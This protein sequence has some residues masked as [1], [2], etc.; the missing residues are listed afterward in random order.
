MNPNNKFQIIRLIIIIVVVL[1]F[2]FYRL[3]PALRKSESPPDENKLLSVL[4]IQLD[5]SAEKKI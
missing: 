3:R 2:L 5:K 1:I 4:L